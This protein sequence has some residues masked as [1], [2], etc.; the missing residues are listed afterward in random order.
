MEGFPLSDHVHGRVP[1]HRGERDVRTVPR[2][3]VNDT[4]GVMTRPAPRYDRT[5]QYMAMIVFGDSESVLK[6]ADVLVRIHSRIVGT[7]P[8]SGLP[9]NANEPE[10]RPAGDVVGEALD[11]ASLAASIDRLRVS[12]RPYLLIFGCVDEAV[13]GEGS[14]PGNGAR[15]TIHHAKPGAAEAPIAE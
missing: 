1:A 10:A 15:S 12:P 13:P 6:A 11:G 3:P 9:C 5:L 8:I 14:C 2:A 7:E 4:Q